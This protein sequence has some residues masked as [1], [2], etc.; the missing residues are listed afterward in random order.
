MQF[1]GVH[2]HQ[3]QQAPRIV[4]VDVILAAALLLQGYRMY[5]VPQAGAMVLLE[6]AGLAHAVR[7]A[8]Q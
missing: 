5:R 2:L 8:Q 6:E 7:A 4:D 3:L 1:Q